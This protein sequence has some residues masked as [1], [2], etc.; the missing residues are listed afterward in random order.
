MDNCK[1][2]IVDTDGHKKMV[3]EID[4]EAVQ[5]KD[6]TGFAMQFA[7]QRVSSTNRSTAYECVPN[8]PYYLSLD[9]LRRI[10]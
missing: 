5:L 2:E 1:C 10:E 9:L 6:Q 4:L 7:M 3:I 8:T